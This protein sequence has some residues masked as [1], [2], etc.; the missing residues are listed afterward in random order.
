MSFDSTESSV[1]NSD[2]LPE[3]DSESADSARSAA[4]SELMRAM[5]LRAIEDL[6]G[7]PEVRAEALLYI[8]NNDDNEYVLSFVSICRYFG[9]DPQKTRDAILKPQKKIRTRRRAA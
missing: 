9:F 8:T 6:N 2:Y 1:G 3:I 7:P 5:I 4:V